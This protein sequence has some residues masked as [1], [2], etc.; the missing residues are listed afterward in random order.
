MPLC[1]E[2]DRSA[3]PAPALVFDLEWRS[4]FGVRLGMRIFDADLKARSAFEHGDFGECST[5]DPE[6]NRKCLCLKSRK[7]DARLPIEG[8]RPPRHSDSKRRA[9]MEQAPIRMIARQVRQTAAEVVVRQK[10]IARR[11]WQC[12][13]A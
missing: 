8:R 1:S 4:A 10:L 9:A 5:A 12:V 7:L 6:S 3:V 11:L 13:Q 2:D